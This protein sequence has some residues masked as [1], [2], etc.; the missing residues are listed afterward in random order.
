MGKKLQDLPKD[1][2]RFYLLPGVLG[3]E[4][5]PS[6]RCYWEAE[7]GH[8]AARDLRICT[9]NVMGKRRLCIKS[10]NGFWAIRLYKD[11]Y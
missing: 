10:E 6:G 2:L 9:R 11:E 8:S 1:P 4:D 3:Q 7:I 5:F